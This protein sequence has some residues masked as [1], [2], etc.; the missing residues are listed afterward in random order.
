MKVY[1][2]IGSDCSVAWNL[3][4][5]GLRKYALPFDWL[6]L[7][8]INTIESLIESKFQYFLDPSYLI[9]ERESDKF[10]LIESNLNDKDIRPII[11]NTKLNIRF[12]H[13]FTNINDLDQVVEKYQRRIDRLYEYLEN[14]DIEKIFVRYTT[15]INDK[16]RLENIFKKLNCQNFKVILIMNEGIKCQSWEKEELDWEKLHT[17]IDKN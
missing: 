4:R 3:S 15:K 10:P 7:S 14:P 17:S 13:D 1:I 16:Q 6:R 12:F 11:K 9:V 2:P 5:L 8:N